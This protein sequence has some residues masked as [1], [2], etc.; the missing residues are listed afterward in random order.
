[1]QLLESLVVLRPLL[2]AGAHATDAQGPSQERGPGG[3]A[4]ASRVGESPFVPCMCHVRHR[5]HP[6]GPPLNP[7]EQAGCPV[8]GG[9]ATAG[10]G[11][12]RA[13]PIE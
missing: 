2:Q 4:G 10:A 9:E 13:F 8:R 5:H 6:V 12:F 11:R 1:M 3:R 7:V